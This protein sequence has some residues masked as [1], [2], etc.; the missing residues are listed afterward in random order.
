MAPWGVFH[1]SFYGLRSFLWGVFKQNIATPDF[2]G[3]AQ[4]NLNA[5]FRFNNAEYRGI[6]LLAFYTQVPSPT[7]L[8]AE[9]LD[10]SCITQWADI[11]GK[12][13]ILGLPAINKRNQYWQQL[14]LLHQKQEMTWPDIL[15][16]PEHSRTSST[17]YHFFGNYRAG[18]LPSYGPLWRS[19]HCS[20]AAI[21]YLRGNI[22][23]VFAIT[24]ERERSDVPEAAEEKPKEAKKERRIFKKVSSI[25]T[26]KIGTLHRK[27]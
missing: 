25:F 7:G 20:E 27:K 14:A 17:L 8:R 22:A 4:A 18:F 11:C 10:E 2:E 21:Q 1:T 12:K 3:S 26:G 16:A 19:A 23:R 6:L 13:F 9:I 5:P 24:F 15:H